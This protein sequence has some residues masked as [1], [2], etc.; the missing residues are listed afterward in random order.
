MT[1]FVVNP[2]DYA[3]AAS[4]MDGVNSSARA[5]VQSLS[6]GLGGSGGM[7]GSDKPA[8]SFSEK[9]DPAVKQALQSAANVIN[10]AGLYATL[11]HA[12]GTNH[13][14]ADGS[15]TIGGGDSSLPGAPSPSELAV[16]S[17]PAAY[18]GPEK[19]PDSLIGHIW[20]LIK[21][22]LMGYVWPN[23]D[24]E[25]LRAAAS[26]WKTAS[27]SIRSAADG[28]PAAV[29]LINAQQAPEVALAAQKHT[30]L[31]KD[32]DSLVEGCSALGDSCEQY[33]QFI[34]DAHQEIIELLL[35]AAAETIAIETASAVF[36]VFSLGAS[37]V[38]G[39]ATVIARLM[40][41]A[42]RVVEIIKGLIAKVAKLVEKLAELAAKL[43]KL[44]VK[45]GGKVGSKVEK[46]TDSARSM[47]CR[48][49][50]KDPVDMATGELLLED[51]DLELPGVLPLRISRTYLS[52]HDGGRIFGPRWSS[53]LDQRLEVDSEGVVVV[54]ED[55]V[56]QWFP[57]PE[58][59][60]TPVS[61]PRGPNWR[62]RLNAQ[63]GAYELVEAASGTT[64]VFSP[65]PSEIPEDRVVEV[66]LRQLR[67]LNG[68]H[69]KFRYDQQGLP[70]LLEHS[71]G[72]TVHVRR[73]GGLVVGLSLASSAGAEAVGSYPTSEAGVVPIVSYERDRA[74]N[75]AGILNGAE[76]R[77]AYNHDAE[78]RL[79]RWVDRNGVRFDYEYDDRNRCVAQVGT[80][81]VMENTFEYL[82][83]P[84]GGVTI[85]TDFAGAVT[86]YETNSRA[87]IVAVTD[88]LGRITR[89]DWDNAD[90][91]LAET[92]P[93]GGRTVWTYTEAGDVAS[94]TRPD[95]ATATFEYSAPGRL[96]RRTDFDGAVW[97]Y[98][99]DKHGR[100]ISITDPSGATTRIQ[101]G[102]TGAEV[103][104]VDALGAVTR[105]EVDSSGLPVAVISPT[106]AKTCYERDLFGRVVRA[107]DPV[108]GETRMRW[109]V[110]G[111]PLEQTGPDGATKRWT[112]DGE[113]NLVS[114]TDEIG[115][116][117]RATYQQFDLLRSTIEADGTETLRERD[118]ELR[119]TSVT[120]HAGLR[121]EY[122][123]DAAGDLVRE[124]DFN[125][126]VV[127]LER[128]SMGRVARRV[129]ASGQSVRFEY[130]QAGNLVKE[131]T[132]T[133]ETTVWTHDLAGRVVSATSPGATVVWERDA[134]GR[135]VSESVDGRVVRF[136]YDVA[137]QRVSS[138]APSGV[139]T[140]YAYDA[141][142]DLVGQ[143]VAGLPIEFARDSFGRTVRRSY[144]Q[145]VRIDRAYD[146]AGRLVHQ[147]A[148]HG[149]ASV[150]ERRW[151]YDP[152]GRVARALDPLR[153]ETRYAF[154]AR[155][156]ITQVIGS[157]PQ[158]AWSERYAYDAADNVTGMQTA[159][160][161]GNLPD[162][163]VGPGAV[164]Y[165]HE[166]TLLTRAG[167]SHYVYDADGRLVRT[168]VTKPDRKPDV[169]HYRYDAYDRLVEVATP[170]GSLWRYAYDALGRRVAKRQYDGARPDAPVSE[171]LF[172]WDGDR[173][174]E[175]SSQADSGAE[176]LTWSYDEGF[177]PLAQIRTSDEQGAVDRRFYAIV[178]DLVGAPTDLYDAATGQL[179]GTA[180]S[181]LYGQQRWHPE[182]T[183]TTPLRFPGQY[184]DAETGLHYNRHRHYDPWTARYTSPDPL[185]LAPA[186][187]QHSYPHDPL[188]WMDP[189]GL[190]GCKDIE[191]ILRSGERPVKGGRTHAGREYQ[192][193]MDRGELPQVPGKQL[194][195][196]GQKLLE[197]ILRHPQ[198]KTTPINGGKFAGGNYV[199]RPDGLGAAV[200]SGKLFQYFGKFAY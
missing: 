51:V 101:R 12:T 94:V 196:A 113:G 100:L 135:V 81:G 139:V 194:D 18:G 180:L 181:T 182:S 33:A 193:H 48:L 190:Y 141:A 66:P 38:A 129:N 20:H 93:D 29:A 5:A 117:V 145:A 174:L 89:T 41:Y 157:D 32:L 124:K 7:A 84:T 98:E 134:L 153:G 11:L 163:P 156:R 197:D 31:K 187:N 138:T 121:W 79:T 130:D 24:I 177:A 72:H 71:S 195:Q 125:G 82:S 86:R 128:D 54:W 56:L 183:A 42:R 165:E 158:Q 191:D 80:G 23:G 8:Q 69:V 123:Y 44:V 15:S 147:R 166:G 188:T 185:G 58:R 61:A 110:S 27:S 116:V 63:A 168:T 112:Y 21:D 159:Q 176:S 154:D 148:G 186:P 152:A 140:T 26:T 76:G 14:E 88:P 107:V 64:K 155:N 96:S 143:T 146:V 184:F 65:A 50:G 60:G 53:T 189:L 87:Q 170:D 97:S 83:T 136:S 47:L 115:Q 16:P 40:N 19:E 9:Y 122:E 102:A 22:Y 169:W 99:H 6:G 178:T 167:R 175:Q 77:L 78:N 13:A 118:P 34:D 161:F 10:T 36:A 70:A 105:V 108:G 37:E 52:F 109:S 198:A 2:S 162:N 57:H 149:A 199:V 160:F 95:G 62:L 131:V 151:A 132:D 142:G 46:A 192:K 137:G 85:N 59:D 67:D 74:G 104:L 150:S 39:N 120:N 49:F 55:G 17:V 103:A 114:I 75:I 73:A 92:A 4:K 200:D 144:G 91:K 28:I 25:K 68:N 43:G 45:A 126:R 172:A 35:Q 90:R 119:L 3:T 106:G 127:T 133:G 30:D 179:A 164:A 1:Y 171:T 111:D 173:L